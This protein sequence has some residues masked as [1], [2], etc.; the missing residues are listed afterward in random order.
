MNP[1]QSI[2]DYN[3][4]KAH[5]DVVAARLAARQRSYHTFFW[6][7]LCVVGI[8][9]ALVVSNA[10]PI[11][12]FI[13]ELVDMLLWSVD[14]KAVSAAEVY[15]LVVFAAY[16]SVLAI[17]YPLRKYR[18]SNSG[19]GVVPREYALKDE[20]YSEIF[21]GLGKFEYAPS[22]GVPEAFLK[23][24]Q[25]LP[26]FQK[27]FMEDYVSGVLQD[28]K[29]YLSE[30]NL[31]EIKNKSRHSVFRGLMLV[32]DISESTIKLRKEF[33]GH[34][35]L[36]ADKH[37]TLPFEKEKYKDYQRVD[38]ADVNLEGM[39]EA[40]T[41]SKEDAQRILKPE[42]LTLIVALNEKLQ[43]SSKQHEHFDNKLFHGFESFAYNFSDRALGIFSPGKL[44][45]EIE[46][47]ALYG[48]TLDVTKSDP[49]SDVPNAI[50]DCP[51]LE[52]YRDKIYFYIPYAHDL[53]ETDSLF[54]PP[55]NDEDAEL[56]YALM[57]TVDKLI[58]III[59]NNN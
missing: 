8:A 15:A 5:F 40:Y 16:L 38:L 32:I 19:A 23:Y 46:Y 7:T 13:A 56:V 59:G 20:A 33:S 45:M 25:A 6:V 39:F 51:H 27:A 1:H 22:G 14:P 57:T 24:S 41:T 42:L 47:E 31:V 12:E 3:T 35:V 21:K 2:P 52:A 54:S 26:V 55:L 11:L 49:K 30:A 48:E 10:R 4:F 43:K 17:A 18:G 58:G 9:L 28:T 50:I 44:P 37:K 36:I 53:Y 29:I 34:T